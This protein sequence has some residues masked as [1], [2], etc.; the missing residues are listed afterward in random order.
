M[1]SIEVNKLPTNVSGLKYR[2]SIFDND[3]DWGI[4]FATKINK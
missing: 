2:P 1:K 4:G 3:L